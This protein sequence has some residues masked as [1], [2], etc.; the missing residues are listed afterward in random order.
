[1]IGVALS[2]LALGLWRAWDG[3]GANIEESRY[4]LAIGATFAALIWLACAPVPFLTAAW[5][6]HVVAIFLVAGTI[7]SLQR[8]FDDWSDPLGVMAHFALPTGLAITPWAAWMAY[9]GH[10]GTASLALPF[11]GVCM[12]SGLAFAYEDKLFGKLPHPAFGKI[13]LDAHRYA[14]LVNGAAH[15]AM[16]ATIAHATA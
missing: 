11:V 15:G 12:L 5:Q 8:G 4:R 6:Q 14:E 2:A 3:A 13:T 16:L 7:W 10:I 9:S 1:M